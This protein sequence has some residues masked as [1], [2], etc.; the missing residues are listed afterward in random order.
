MME[1]ILITG[2]AG[3]LGKKVTERFLD[4]GYRV[5][6][7]ISKNGEP[8]F[9]KHEQL[10]V[11]QADLMD[12]EDAR[13][14]IQKAVDA[15]PGIEAGILLV[16]GFAMG[17]IQKTSLKEIEKMYRLNFVT[18]YNTARSL[19]EIMESQESGGQ[20]IFIGARPVLDPEAARQ[21]VAYTLSKSL[22]FK[23]AEVINAEGRKK[24]ITASVVVPSIIDTPANRRAMPEADFSRWV[25]TEDI[26]DNL[27]HLL[28]PAGR[29]LRKTVFRV[30]GDS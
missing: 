29:K 28:T 24:G 23:L 20:I 7:L 16:G 27:L 1:H 12:E 19:L 14:V 21:M 2:A 15:A 17:P 9:I 25:T 5:S 22:I 30:Y 8:G 6:A 10:H 26:A 11:Y 3:G 18:A 4:S 13:T